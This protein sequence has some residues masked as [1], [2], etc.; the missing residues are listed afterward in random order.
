MPEILLHPKIPL[1]DDLE[2]EIL[3]A[4][5]AAG[6]MND[7]HTS[8]YVSRVCRSSLLFVIWCRCVCFLLS[9]LETSS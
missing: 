1:D 9:Y 6:I 3:R 7:A 5:Y 8:I 4:Y 2:Q